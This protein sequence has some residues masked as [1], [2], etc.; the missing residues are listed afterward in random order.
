MPA[1]PIMLSTPI[2]LRGLGDDFNPHA[3]FTACR[4]CGWLM[5]TREDRESFEL[6]KSDELDDQFKAKVI[7]N[8]QVILRHNALDKHNKTEHP[9]YD[10]EIKV[11]ELMGWAFMPNAAH[12]LAP[13]GITPLGNMHEEI[14]D[15]LATAP[16][17]PSVGS[18]HN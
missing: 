15:A 18:S 6:N 4:L 11:L 2:G 7:H 9:N 17:A 5:Q 3:P 12:K 1:E 13:F 10:N 14:V 8:N 16:R